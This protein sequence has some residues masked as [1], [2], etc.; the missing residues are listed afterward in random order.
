MQQAEKV[1]E[2]DV[3]TL[4]WLQSTNLSLPVIKFNTAINSA[5]F[6]SFLTEVI[7]HYV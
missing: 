2:H 7:I 4:G 3:W 5:Y 6:K 1:D